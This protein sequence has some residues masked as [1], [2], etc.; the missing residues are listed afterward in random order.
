M[1]WKQF[2]SKDGKFTVSIPGQ[3]IEE[4]QS[5]T[6]PKSPNM[7]INAHMYT[8]DQLKEKGVI[9]MFSYSDY[10]QE[11]VSNTD[12][13]TLL[14]GARDGAVIKSKG[15]LLF[16][17]PI[18]KGRLK[19]RELKVKIEENMIIRGRIYIFKNRLYQTMAISKDDKKSFRSIKRY[20][21]SFNLI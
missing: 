4:V 20:L 12:P 9:Y 21:D 7:I 8:L 15:T 11:N 19:G 14:N 13:E 17:K 16:E 3:P 10:P 5:F 1:A 18:A 6:L 2:V